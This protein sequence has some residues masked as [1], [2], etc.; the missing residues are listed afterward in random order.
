M[1]HSHSPADDLTPKHPRRAPRVPGGAVQ[2]SLCA[3]FK[4][5]APATGEKRGRGRVAPVLSNVTLLFIEI[6]AD[7]T[8]DFYA[9]H[10]VY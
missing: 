2:F 7:R 4:L 10:T 3:A 1:P 5:F 6:Y 9:V 8:A